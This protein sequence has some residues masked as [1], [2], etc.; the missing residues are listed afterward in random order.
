MLKRLLWLALALVLGLLLW[1]WLR[2]REEFSS[3]HPQFAP[4]PPSFSPAPD[5]PVAATSSGIPAEPLSAGMGAAPLTTEAEEPLPPGLASTPTL[6]ESERQEGISGVSTPAE[7]LPK[8]EP[9]STTS[10]ASRSAG[11]E[12]T[13]G[14]ATALVDLQDVDLSQTESEDELEGIVGY[15]MRCRTKRTI[16]DAHEHITES[17]RR[18]ARGTC[19][20]CGTNMFTFL[21]DDTDG[22][23]SDDE[24]RSSD[25]TRS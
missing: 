17:G 4:P 25:E 3:A 5:V 10:P 8:E 16:Q 12:P 15:C 18:A 11:Q 7:Q 9:A 13:S 20:V 1:E 24:D 14:E 2:R 19:P 23:E 22:T 6:S 21:K